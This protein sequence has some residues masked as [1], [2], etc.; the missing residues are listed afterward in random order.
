MTLLPGSMGL[1]LLAT[2][3]NLASAVAVCVAIFFGALQVR[4]MQK[5]RAVFTTA[6]LVHAMQSQDFTRSVGLV[7]TLPEN[8]DP[9]LIRKDPEMTAAVQTLGHVFE[10]LGVLVFHRIMNLYMVD[11]LMGGYVRESW[12]RVGP[13]TRARRSELGVYYGEWM[14]WL[15][16]Q[17]D[18]HPSPGKAIGAHVAH[19]DWTP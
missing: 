14:E 3:A 2:L 16:M 5:T 19:R 18:K 7:L 1:M 10:S 8:A 6:E 12:A 11:D 4:Q 9:E 15:V 13:Y 17:L